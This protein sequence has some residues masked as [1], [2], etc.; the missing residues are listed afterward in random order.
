MYEDG[1]PGPGGPRDGPWDS[2][3]N[4]SDSFP[5]PIHPTFQFFIFVRGPSTH[6]VYIPL[7]PRSGVDQGLLG[8]D[9]GLREKV[10]V[11]NSTQRSPLLRCMRGL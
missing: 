10:R 9:D 3:R 11:E 7:D 8:V 2:G 6:G 4:P 1:S 5:L